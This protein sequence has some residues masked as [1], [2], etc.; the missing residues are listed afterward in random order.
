MNLGGYRTELERALAVA[1]YLVVRHGDA[2]V[3]VLERLEREVEAE[4]NQVDHRSR[5]ARI[6]Q[7]L[8]REV[9]SAS[10]V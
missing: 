10:G 2:Y 9:R 7:S 5:A 6:L 3:P 1:A 8:T 4:R